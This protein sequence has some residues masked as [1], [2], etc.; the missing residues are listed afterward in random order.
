MKLTSQTKTDMIS[1]IY[2]LTLQISAIWA[3]HSLTLFTGP[4][5]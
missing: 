1:S 4:T 2:Q 3:T 5:S